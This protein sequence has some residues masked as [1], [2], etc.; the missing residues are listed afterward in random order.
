MRRSGGTL[1]TVLC[2]YEVIMFI[3]VSQVTDWRELQNKVCQLFNEM[4]YE[5]ETTKTVELA[6]RGAKEIDVYVKDP[7]ASHNQI[8][9]I[10]CKHWESNVPQEV[11]H[12][13]KFVME[14]AGANTGF[15]VSKKG[16]QSGAS[17][18]ARFTNIQLV[19]FEELQHLYGNEWFRKQKAKLTPYF[20]KIRSIY[21]VHF[22]QFNLSTIYNNM[23]FDTEDL[24]SK[25]F[26]YHLWIGNLMIAMSGQFPESYLGPEPVRLATNPSDPLWKSDSW[27]E[28]ATVRDYFSTMLAAV[29]RCVGEFEELFT[30]ANERFESLPEQEQDEWFSRT[31]QRMNEETPIRVLKSKLSPDEYRR[32]L[33]LL[34]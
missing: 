4:G 8:Y 34:L 19:T 31:L 16:F 10:E 14:S 20:E 27:F 3:P 2:I 23:R 21:L 11:V 5:A 25:L 33:D 18:A 30:S 9:L 26:Y 29:Q 32:L 7:L 1:P 6:G 24:K 15:I 22:Q 28:I 13:F 17:E 12:G